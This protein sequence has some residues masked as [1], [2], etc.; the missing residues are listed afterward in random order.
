MPIMRRDEPREN[1]KVDKIAIRKLQN[2]QRES[3]Y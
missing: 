2:V 1:Y 3:E